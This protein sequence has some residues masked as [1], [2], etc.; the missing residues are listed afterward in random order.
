MQQSF[1]NLESFLNRELTVNTYIYC[2]SVFSAFGIS[3]EQLLASKTKVDH[4]K[5]EKSIEV[6]TE[7]QGNTFIPIWNDHEMEHSMMRANYL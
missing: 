6:K 5:P 1:L 7:E 2:F 3:L 4:L